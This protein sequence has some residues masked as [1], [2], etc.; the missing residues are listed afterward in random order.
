MTLNAEL[1]R[2]HREYCGGNWQ[3][4]REV[5]D[6]LMRCG[7]ERHH[8]VV[9]VGCGSL[10]IGTHLITFLDSGRYTGI[11]PEES[12]LQAGVNHEI[13][14]ELL[15]RQQPT[16]LV[17]AIGA[18]QLQAD[19][20]I[21]WNVFNHLSPAMLRRALETVTADRWFLD[22]HVSDKPITIPA[23]GQGWS[24]RYADSKAN[25]YTRESL[26]ELTAGAGYSCEILKTISD[27]PWV[28]YPLEILCLRRNL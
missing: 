5:F 6:F 15:K 14:A 25:S 23:D 7:L 16:F 24:Y 4:W 18:S 11:E 28:G 27:H 19:W 17:E 2:D 9:E 21:A 26:K 12:M 22:V 10:R 8:S 13:S 1:L 3:V 20:A